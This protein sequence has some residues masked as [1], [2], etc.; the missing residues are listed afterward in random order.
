MMA[1]GERVPLYITDFTA[2]TFID[3]QRVP[4]GTH[5]SNT[6]KILMVR[7]ISR[8]TTANGRWAIRQ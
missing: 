3:R 1:K 4:G 2:K 6:A 7:G 5:G 8:K